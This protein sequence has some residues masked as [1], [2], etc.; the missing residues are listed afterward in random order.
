MYSNLITSGLGLDSRKAEELKA[1]GLDTVQIS[2]QADEAALADAIAGARAHAKKLEAVAAAR[3]ADLPW[4][5]NVVLHR[6]N[7][8]RMPKFIRLA[9]CL[10]AFRIELANTQFYGWAFENRP[11]LLPTRDQLRRAQE[12]VDRERRRVDGKL[13][14]VYVA[15]DYYEKRPKACLHGWGTVA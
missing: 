12:T 10:G 15:C 1:A 5:A 7:I 11:Y 6:R 14:L 13:Q 8:D 4:S 9:E 3:K 2:F